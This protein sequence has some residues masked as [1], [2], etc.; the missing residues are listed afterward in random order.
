MLTQGLNQ[1]VGAWIGAHQAPGHRRALLSTREVTTQIEALRR[2]FFVHKGTVMFGD[3]WERADYNSGTH[4]IGIADNA[5]EI[6]DALNAV[7]EPMR[8]AGLERAK[9]RMAEYRAKVGAEIDA[10]QKVLDASV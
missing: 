1:A 6:A 3:P 4:E 8:R 5:Q 2:K 7:I 10:L 9:A